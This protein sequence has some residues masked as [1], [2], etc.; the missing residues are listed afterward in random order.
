MK[1]LS[2]VLFVLFVVGCGDTV[3]EDPVPIKH[4]GPVTT[5][6]AETPV[7]IEVTGTVCDF[8]GDCPLAQL[9]LPLKAASDHY[10]VKVCQPACEVTPYKEV[11][12]HVTDG[13]NKEITTIV[14]YEDT[15][16]RHSHTGDHRS[17]HC[18]QSTGLCVLDCVGGNDGGDGDDDGG[19]GGDADGDGVL[20]ADDNC[21]FTPNA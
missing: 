7:G 17:M 8:D 16:K 15:C 11:T 5:Q 6:P 9:C 3:Y 21:P 2:V 19:D 13:G 14:V 10:V 1:K 4:E 12:E 18:N 20:D